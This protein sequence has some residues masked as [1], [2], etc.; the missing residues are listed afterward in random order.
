[1]QVNSDTGEEATLDMNQHVK[2][3]SSQRPQ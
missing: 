1:M 2:V 3:K